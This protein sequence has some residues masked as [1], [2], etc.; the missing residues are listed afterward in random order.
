MPSQTAAAPATSPMSKAARTREISPSTNV[1]IKD[2]RYPVRIA[3]RS[4]VQNTVA[5]VS[6]YVALPPHYKG[7]HMSR[8]VDVLH[9]HREP[10]PWPRSTA[11]WRSSAGDWMRPQ[12]RI[13]L[14]FPYFVNK[15]APVSGVRSM[16]DYEVTLSR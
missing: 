10:F 13:E 14:T 3:D 11:C 16:I 5:S 15:R 7:T 6:M 4:G 8:F 2:L 1:G 9:G 12:G